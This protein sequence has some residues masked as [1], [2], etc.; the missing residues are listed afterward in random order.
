MEKH[1]PKLKESCGILVQDDE[2]NIIKLGVK[3]E[4]IQ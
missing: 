2:L 4:D 3:I 1:S